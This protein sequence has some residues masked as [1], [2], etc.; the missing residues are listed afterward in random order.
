MRWRQSLVIVCA[1][2]FI[3]ACVPLVI[4]PGEAATPPAISGEA[5][6]TQD[7]ITLPLRTWKPDNGAPPAAVV[8]ALHG[9]NEYSRFFDDVGPWLAAH[10]GIVSYAYD[11]RGF[12]ET[13][14][15]GV[16]P[17]E[18]ALVEDLTSAITAVQAR[19]P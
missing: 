19:H 12:G 17:G 8:I 13:V 3:G 18:A 2:L 15:R 16:W 7:G 14:N 9:F 4:P 1:I 11:Q 10:F 6:V 5:L